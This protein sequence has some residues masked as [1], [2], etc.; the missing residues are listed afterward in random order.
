MYS[1]IQQLGIFC[2]SAP[3]FSKCLSLR[4]LWFGKCW[5]MLLTSQ[6]HIKTMMIAICYYFM[7]D[8]L[9]RGSFLSGLWITSDT[10]WF[11]FFI[12]F[13]CLGNWA[14]FIPLGN[15]S[16]SGLGYVCGLLERALTVL[17]S[18]LDG[19][20][21]SLVSRQL[22]LSVKH[23]LSDNERYHQLQCLSTIR[24]LST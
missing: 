4:R 20:F 15:F 1:Q 7:P 21:W 23:L 11:P 22:Q 17:V 9:F 12:N 2:I 18:V 14:P 16:R 10:T 19:A 8:E 13:F 5:L 3:L 6:I 24:P